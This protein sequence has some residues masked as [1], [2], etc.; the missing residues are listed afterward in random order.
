[1]I[2]EQEFV[3]KCLTEAEKF[4][5]SF[6]EARV[7]AK[8]V[9]NVEMKKGQINNAQV[10]FE[11]GFNV[12]IIMNGAWG[13]A[14]S[15]RFTDKE[16]PLVLKNASNVSKASAQKIRRPVELTEEPIITDTYNTPFKINPFDVDF[17]E[18]VELLSL[19]DSSMKETGEQV[20]VTESSI[21]SYNVQLFFGN[22][23]GT[24]ITQN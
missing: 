5:I 4:P 11:R 3:E 10:T 24:R 15:S 19:S 21:D 17:Q 14:T 6:A 23:E 22:S 18:K 9:E 12:R 2:E 16:I 7:F 1:M 8:T 13:Y 20:K